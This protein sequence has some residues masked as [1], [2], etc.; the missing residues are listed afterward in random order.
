[1][2]DVAP[3]ALETAFDGPLQD[4]EALVLRQRSVVLP[5]QMADAEIAAVLSECLQVP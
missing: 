1:L 3:L 4:L 2:G 5:S